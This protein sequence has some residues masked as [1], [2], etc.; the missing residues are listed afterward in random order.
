MSKQASSS[1]RIKA[2]DYVRA[3]AILF[4]IFTHEFAIF[5]G[6]DKYNSKN[7]AWIERTIGSWA[8]PM[9]LMVAGMS[10]VFY[11]EKKRD[12]GEKITS[13]V[14]KRGIFIYL[15]GCFLSFLWNIKDFY[16]V[17]FFSTDVLALIGISTIL[18]YTFYSRSPLWLK[19]LILFVFLALTPFLQQEFL[20]N[21][22]YA[23]QDWA[24]NLND[25]LILYLTNGIF[26]I[27]PYITFVMFGWILG[28]LL[29]KTKVSD[30]NNKEN[31]Y[32]F[33]TFI[34]G[35][36]LIIIAY[37]LMPI[38]YE[39]KFNR[40]YDDFISLYFGV[41]I[42]FLSI[43]MLIEKCTPSEKDYLKPLSE[44]S[45]LSFSI[46]FFDQLFGIY[47]DFF[48]IE[49]LLEIYLALIIVL[50]GIVLVFIISHIWLKK[51]RYGLLEWMIRKIS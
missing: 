50:A 39:W 26:P 1:I 42:L 37:I 21:G 17:D 28:E 40:Y 48:E 10:L 31:I 20:F 2:M 15:V 5:I 51:F 23:Y 22:P 46:Y 38:N 13:S 35:I 14:V 45:V 47:F 3:I 11:I 43:F 32:I 44:I 4:M 25:V 36:I 29:F 7:I 27:F 33:T 19:F 8:A 6:E 34:M 24:D 16:I 18:V 49:P 30:G 41:A 12:K 9:F